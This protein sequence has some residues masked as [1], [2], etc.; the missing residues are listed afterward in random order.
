MSNNSERLDKEVV[1]YFLSKGY[2]QAQAR[3]I[4]A[5]VHAESRSDP[6]VRGG[7]KGRAVGLGQWL[8]PRRD[9]LFRRYGERPTK[10]QQLDFLHYELQ[11]GDH[12]GKAVLQAKDEGSVLEA[13]INK[14]MRPAKGAET[15]GDMRR[16]RAALG[17]PP[18]TY[19]TDPATGTPEPINPSIDDLIYS[20][21]DE[22]F[23]NVDK[24][25]RA[26]KQ[27]LQATKAPSVADTV[28]S[29]LTGGRG[30]IITNPLNDTA[31]DDTAQ[32][33]QADIAE[34]QKVEAVTA[35][36]ILDAAWGETLTAGLID[37]ADAQVAEYDP[38]FMAEYRNNWQAIEAFAK[39]EDEVDFI[40]EARS[41]EDLV[42]IQNEILER[43]QSDF[44]LEASGAPTA[45]RLTAG[46]L[47]PAGWAAGAGVGKAFQ[48]GRV[49]G[50]AAIKA[51]QTTR[52]VTSLAVEGAAGNLA[53]TAGLDAT[54]DFVSDREYATS[55]IGGLIIG[56]SI[57]GITAKFSGPSVNDEL[58]AAYNARQS[59]VAGVEANV[60]AAMPD[61]PQTQI[62]DAVEK[63]VQRGY[64]DT[65]SAALAD[66]PEGQRLMVAE[67]LLTEHPLVKAAVEGDNDLAS[68]SDATMRAMTA[69]TVA[70]SEAIVAANPIKEQDLNTILERVGFESTALRLLKS[71]SPVAKAVALTLLEKPGAQGGRG[72]TAALT[73]AARE[74][75]YLEQLS[76]YE[77]I[78]AQWRRQQGGSFTKNLVDGEWNNKF[79]DRVFAELE[80][81]SGQPAG[82]TFDPD[83]LV[84][85][86]ADQFEKGMEVMR[87][88]QQ[89]VGTVGS[90]RLGGDSVGY[91]P[92][93]LDPRKVLQMTGPQQARVRSVMSRQ[94]QTIEGFDAEFSD[95]LA[96][97][98]LERAIDGAH[99]Q[100]HVPVN[101][102]SPEA[103]EMIEDAI[104]AMGIATDEA[105]KLLGKFARGGAGHTKRR[106][107]LDLFE[108]IGDGKVLKDL[109]VT[110]VPMLY[111]SYARRVSGEVALAQ[112]GIMGKKGLD[113]ISKAMRETGAAPKD[114]EAFDQIAAEF[115]NTPYGQSNY[116]FL[117]T[118]MDNIRALTSAARLGG[119]GFTQFAEFGNAIPALGVQAAL[120]GVASMPRLIGEV[121]ALAKG[122]ASESPLLSSLDTLG[123]QLGMEDYHVTRMFDV[124]D[125]NVQLYDSDSMGLFTRFSRG[126]AHATMVASGHRLM[127]AVQ[128]RA[129]AEQII[130][131]AVKYAKSGE[132][133]TA[134]DD[135]GI[136][137]ALR[138]AVRK[139]LPNIAE[140]DDSGD[141]VRLDLFK[142]KEL[143]G[144]QL[145]ELQQAI[146]RGAGQII[147]RTYIGETGKW[148]HSSFLKLLTQ[149]RTFSITAVEKQW[150]RNVQNYG[151]MRAFVALAA[152]ASFALP[153]HLARV[154]VNALAKP[155]DERAEYIEKNTHPLALTRA[156]LN[157]ASA[158]GLSG[159]VFDVGASLASSYG[160]D[161]GEAFGE[162][163]GVRGKQGNRLVGGVIAP[164][165]GL[166]NDV[167][168]GIAGGDPKKVVRSMPGSNL[169]YVSPF[170]TAA[171]G[172]FDE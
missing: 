47:D 145:A 49:G 53:V 11:G 15:V 97:K 93:R 35:G 74:R 144:P 165:V 136:T 92:H 26:Q 29:A 23:A 20:T 39:T 7:Y 95:R 161:F 105:N 71:E 113:V 90:A 135:M 99:G 80:A 168:A 115:L 24:A 6:N 77:N 58:D 4:A 81:R 72:R 147:Q 38:N 65:L 83:P 164:G 10:Q 25:Q 123:G 119:M 28:R 64:L 43:R 158:S 73:K 124:K 154:Q 142:A 118:S 30:S 45:I 42:R 132:A 98:Y 46:V 55:V 170:V 107:K 2:S 150:G 13:Y 63:E 127:V 169:P 82:T 79:N 117:D 157:Y 84:V 44:A 162:G 143:R 148:A 120:K 87:I 112:Y 167:Y 14:F 12:G 100:F 153:I 111:R 21:P 1:N 48:L 78:G 104:K 33:A 89:R 41:G 36:D 109:F 40:R 3:G 122:G 69:E 34:Q 156:T 114:T 102:Y 159:D 51:G 96:A 37:A 138:E 160:G 155:E 76:G 22:L 110:D 128:T 19:N 126:A 18:V 171:L 88:E 75:V 66:V 60:R 16:G 101:L 163:Y 133:D 121:Q 146:E 152:T 57:G 131:K 32:V 172:V 134:L 9:E 106:L 108:D 151:A 50:F 54:G 149:F 5:G 141:I 116:R 129:M 31:I 67:E 140:F 61:A 130:R 59:Y 91:V 62:D 125:N 27:K 137:P 166:A 139:D 56:G 52:G 68:I 86:A 85:K 103:A 17:L 8:G 70:R 94:F